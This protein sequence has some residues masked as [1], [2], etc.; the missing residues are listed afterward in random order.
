MRTENIYEA[1]KARLEDVVQDIF[2]EMQGEL[3]IL[4]GD[5]APEMD[6]ALEA[7]TRIFAKQISIV[8]EEQMSNSLE[9][10]ETGYV[11]SMDTTTI[12]RNTYGEGGELQSRE[13]VGFY[14][15]EPNTK[16]T[17]LYATRG[18]KCTYAE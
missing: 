10:I 17:L 2:T 13:V 12:W 11:P 4:S 1:V 16:D 5:I 9:G 18:T 3:G 7:K 8:L 15:G 14:N 6:Y